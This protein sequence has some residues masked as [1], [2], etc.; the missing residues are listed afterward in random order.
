MVACCEIL[1][2]VSLNTSARFY[3]HSQYFSQN[4]SKIK[5]LLFQVF[6]CCEGNERC[7]EIGC[8]VIADTFWQGLESV[9]QRSKLGVVQAAVEQI[10]SFE[11]KEA[12]E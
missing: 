1:L 12:A 7:I 9:R 4:S 11:I 10:P 6:E 3:V 8:S 2:P 5:I